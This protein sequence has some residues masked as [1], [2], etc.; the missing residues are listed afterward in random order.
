MLYNA[1]LQLDPDDPYILCSQLAYNLEHTSQPAIL[2][3]ARPAMLRALDTCR[4]HVAADVQLPRAWFTMGRLHLLLGQVSAAL[5]HYAKAIRFHV[6][7]EGPAWQQRDFDAEIEFLEQIRGTRRDRL[8]AL[9]WSEQLL[10]M[11]RWLREEPRPGIEEHIGQAAS[12]RGFTPGRRVLIVAGAT[13]PDLE[14]KMRQDYETLLEGALDDLDGVVVSGGTNIGIPGLVGR[15]AASL[16]AKGRKRFELIGYQPEF[17]RMDVK[18]S[19]HYDHHIR[20]GEEEA[21][22]LGEPLRMWLDM[23][24]AGVDPADVRLLG[25]NGGD[26]SRFEYALALAMGAIVGL[27]ESS[28]RSADLVLRVSGLV[29]ARDRSDARDEVDAHEPPG[30][31][32][33]PDDRPGLRASR[34]VRS[35]RR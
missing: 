13:R 15:V 12:F 1:A 19:E 32:E 24:A 8:P 25:I 35:G 22:G 27:V 14:T 2:D 11:G 23:L 28:D 30:A 17:A 6:R 33:R 16:K 31:A 29:E 20:S 3:S 10:R 26:V 5:D 21:H 34:R 7:P 9:A 18:R 4:A